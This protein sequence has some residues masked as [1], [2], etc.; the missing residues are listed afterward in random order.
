MYMMFA[1]VMKERITDVTIAGSK[2][3]L[4]NLKKS[5]LTFFFFLMDVDGDMVLISC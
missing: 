4:V 2:V 5:L 1:D 3:E